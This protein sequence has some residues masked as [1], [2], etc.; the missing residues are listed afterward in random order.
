MPANWEQI[1]R[2]R[3]D[4][5]QSL[6]YRVFDAVTTV[7]DILDLFASLCEGIVSLLHF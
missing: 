5:E 3:E 6:A 7:M 1:V 2:A 4:P